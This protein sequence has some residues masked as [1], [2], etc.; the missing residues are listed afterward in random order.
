M[1]GFIRPACRSLMNG[2]DRPAKLDPPPVQP[3]SRSGVSPASSSW[4]SASSPMTVWCSSTWLSTLPRAYLVV[5]DPHHPDLALKAEQ[6]AAE[7]ERRS[8]LP[9]AGLG[10]DLAGALAGVVESLG[11]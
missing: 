8:P 2:K 7:G 9:G 1:V 10:G 3:T 6:L 4:R 11:D 5:G